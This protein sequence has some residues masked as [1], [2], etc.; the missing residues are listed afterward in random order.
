MISI[1]TNVL[2]RFL[3][4]DDPEQAALARELL[5]VN[6]VWIS[7]TVLLEAAW[8]LSSRYGQRADEIAR[9]FEAA[10][11]IPTI[12]VEDRAGIRR[13]LAWVKA[14]MDIPDAL[15]LAARATRGGFVT[16]DR[17][18]AALAASL[19]DVPEVRFLG[20]RKRA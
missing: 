12:A 10:I 20:R 9:A 4:R 18:L 16:F 19:A 3:V 14:G 15:H 13:A 7:R 8:V 6:E 11:R 17:N 2:V 1:D 5:T